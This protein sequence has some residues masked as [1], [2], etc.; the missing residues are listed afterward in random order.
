MTDPLTVL[1]GDALK[2]LRTLPDQS[3]QCCVTS[4]PYWG[5][6]D[7]GTATWEG[8]EPDCDHQPE[9][10]FRQFK[11]GQGEIFT[12]TSCYAEKSVS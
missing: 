9:R 10:K 3:V 8:G 5:L 4:P 11:N 1:Q 6:R 7:Y 2:Q 12:G